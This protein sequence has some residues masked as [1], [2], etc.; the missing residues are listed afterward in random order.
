MTV[1]I[2]GAVFCGE[3]L[4]RDGAAGIDTNVEAVAA[5][6]PLL[7][8]DTSWRVSRVALVREPHPFETVAGFPSGGLGR[9]GFPGPV[10]V[11]LVSVED[12]AAAVGATRL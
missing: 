12:P 3:Y 10:W 4:A 7:P 8:R 1:V 6:R 2:V 5:T 11:V 9:R